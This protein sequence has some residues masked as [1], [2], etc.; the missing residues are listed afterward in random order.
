M[1]AEMKNTSAS[2]ANLLPNGGYG[3]EVSSGPNTVGVPGDGNLIAG[4]A[5][6]GIG[7][8][9]LVAKRTTG[10]RRPETAPKVRE[11]TKK[12]FAEGIP[13]Y[14]ADALR[15]TFAALA[16]L[17]RGKLCVLAWRYHDE[18]VPGPAADVALKINGLPPKVGRRN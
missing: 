10:L 4:N 16:S 1:R 9:D 8:D 11:A 15:F 7:I 3:V 18:D 6:D 2:G 14:G 12:E 5:Y 13:G 17:D